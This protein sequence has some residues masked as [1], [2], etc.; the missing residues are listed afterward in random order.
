MDLARTSV[1]EIFNY[2]Y[3]VVRTRFLVTEVEG[4]KDEL[5]ANIKEE[6]SSDGEMDSD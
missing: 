4:I 2:Y 3:A 5:K 6:L 1:Q